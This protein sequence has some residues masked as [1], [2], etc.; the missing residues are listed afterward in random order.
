MF[1]T[2][3][4]PRPPSGD[5]RAAVH[6]PHGAARSS[7]VSLRIASQQAAAPAQQAAERA[8]TVVATTQSQLDHM[9]MRGGP[10]FGEAA[11]CVCTKARWA[12]WSA[13]KRCDDGGHVGSHCRKGRAS[14]RARH[15][16][17]ENFAASTCVMFGAVNQRTA[18]GADCAPGVK[19]VDIAAG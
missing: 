13:A 9:A 14:G 18:F 15:A 2:A 5:V 1:G 12:T 19:K 16:T 3:D 17:S 10:A 8:M 11:T 7:A 4:P 6:A